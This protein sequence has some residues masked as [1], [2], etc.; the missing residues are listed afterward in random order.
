[1]INKENIKKLIAHLH[2]KCSQL[3]LSRRDCSEISLNEIPLIKSQELSNENEFYN[4]I[5]DSNRTN[6]TICDV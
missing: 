2:F 5:G 4:I 1:M 6:A 3:H